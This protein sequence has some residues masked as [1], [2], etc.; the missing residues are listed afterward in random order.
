MDPIR[1]QQIVLNLARNGFDS[2]SAVNVTYGRV[3]IET[4]AAENGIVQVTVR[5]NG[6]GIPPDNQ[7]KVFERFYTTKEAGI[8]MGLDTCRT[9]VERLGSRIW[10]EDGRN[11]T[12]DCRFTLPARE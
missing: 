3:E 9:L 1:L 11:V 6:P 5:D 7:D 4:E 10:L 12:S 2:V 8:G